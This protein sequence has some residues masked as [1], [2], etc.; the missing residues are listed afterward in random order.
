MNIGTRLR[1]SSLAVREQIAAGRTRLAT[2]HDEGA[3][4]IQVAAQWTELIDEA[5]LDL[6]AAAL[7]DLQIPRETFDRFAAVVIH[8]S[9]GR[10]DPSPYS[11]LDVML[12]H[13]PGEEASIAPFAKRFVGDLFDAGMSAGHAVFTPATAVK[14]AAAEGK[15]AT[16]FLDGRLLAGSEALWNDFLQRFRRVSKRRGK[17]LAKQIAGERRDE[18]VAYGETV[19]LLEPN[20]KRSPGALRDLQS[21]RWMGFAV[22]GKREYDDLQL[23][24]AM[25]KQDRRSIRSA[26]AFLLRLRNELHFHAQRSHDVLDRGEQQRIAEKWGFA[27]QNGESPVEVFMREYFQHTHKAAR[28]AERFEARCTARP[29]LRALGGF[30]SHQVEGDYRAAPSGIRATGAGRR[31]LAAGGLSEILRLVDLANLYDAPIDSNLWEYVR[32]LADE[33][34]AAPLEA[35]AAERFLSILGQPARLYAILCDLH[36]I[37]LLEQVLPGF[38]H[39]RGLLQFN[40]YH[41]YTVDEH[42]LRTVLEAT[43]FRSRTDVLGATYRELDDRR[44]LHLSLLLHDLGKGYGGDHSEIGETI[45]GDA[46][47]RLRLPPDET[48]TVKFL[49]RQ[50]LTLAHTALWR[51]LSDEKTIVDFAVKV[52]TPERLR[53]LYLLTAADI[54]GVGPGALNDWKLALLTQLYGKALDRLAGDDVPKPVAGVAPIAAAEVIALM[55]DEGDAAQ[56]RR[57]Y[58]SLPHDLLATA[59]AESIAELL[60]RIE[61]APKDR[62]TAWS[63]FLPE[64]GTVEYTVLGCDLPASGVCYRLTGALAAAG[65]RIL[66]AQIYT[67]PDDLV[68]DRFEVHDPDFDGEPPE[69]RT[70]DVCRRLERSVLEEKES[71]PQFRKTWGTTSR[72]DA[73]SFARAPTKILTDM[74]SSA[75]FTI[76]DVFAHDRVGLLYT[77]TKTIYDLGLNVH[78]AKIGSHLDQVVDVFYVTD[79]EGRKIK[80]PDRLAD[81]RNRLAAAADSVEASP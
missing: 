29:L 39:A 35:A 26:R 60:R 58:Q 15:L 3:P 67:L 28:I 36:E 43:K 5:V 65:L 48:D 13:G 42:S 21:V 72:A 1:S 45:A 38:R 7:S 23:A 50:H 20:V 81:V 44:L 56:R 40:N 41:K 18:R 52:G 75:Q 66:S 34:P 53:L 55:G 64:R 54:A 70:Q 73:P 10:R 46:A 12:L 8:G 2:L 33:L 32:N 16:S 31:K 80:D 37:G 74:K 78:R 14:H 27:P 79:L 9:F 68:F 30:L 49:V 77:L 62:P 11:D 63:R 57:T 61:T 17:R 6:L 25:T 24:G 69:E 19:Y 4:G 47:A 59:T 71:A 76:I 22:Y 51:D